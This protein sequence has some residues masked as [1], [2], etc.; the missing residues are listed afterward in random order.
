[1]GNNLDQER[2]DVSKQQIIVVETC[3][4]YNNTQI[5]TI[6]TIFYILIYKVKSALDKASKA[7]RGNRGTALLF[8]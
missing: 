7:H 1:M 2:T 8:L 4:S 6:S 3:T 5:I